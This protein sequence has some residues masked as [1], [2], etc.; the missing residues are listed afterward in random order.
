M[1]MGNMSN[2]KK[3]FLVKAAK[4]VVSLIVIATLFILVNCSDGVIYQQ[5]DDCVEI[6]DD[7][8]ETCLV[9]SGGENEYLNLENKWKKCFNYLDGKNDNLLDNTFT[10]S[11]ITTLGVNVSEGYAEY[12]G[13]LNTSSLG[14]SECYYMIAD[15]VLFL[16]IRAGSIPNYAE[17]GSIDILIKDEKICKIA[18]VVLWDERDGEHKTVWGEN[19]G[20]STPSKAELKDIVSKNVIV[21]DGN[22]IY[23]GEIRSETFGFVGYTYAITKSTL[24]IY[25]YVNYI[26]VFAKDGKIEIEYENDMIRNITKVVL[27]DVHDDGIKRTIWNEK[28]GFLGSEGEVEPMESGLGY[29]IGGYIERVQCHN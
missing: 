25:P 21:G 10:L 29:G 24:Y 20:F 3:S 22:V 15:D 27:G 12:K 18:K 28:S 5:T 2:R 7:N 11:N 1:M 6:I 9:D 23:Q 14:I 4:R 13:E 17:S 26:P 8:N 19:N 16:S